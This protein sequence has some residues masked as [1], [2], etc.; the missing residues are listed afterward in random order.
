METISC[1]TVTRPGKLNQL[2]R[3][4]RCFSRQTWTERELV[5]VH[6][7]GEALQRD[8]EALSATFS[9][10]AIRVHEESPGQPLGTLRNASVARAR[11]GLVCQWDDDDLY[12]PQRLEVQAQRLREEDAE[13]CFFTDQMHL[14]TQTGEMYWDDW[15]REQPPMH[16]I[17]GTLLG[18]RES[19]APYPPLSRGEDTPLLRELVRRGCR[20]AEL[21]DAGCLYV[22]VYDGANAFDQEHHARISAWKRRPR[23]ALLANADA[24]LA[25]LQGHEWPVPHVFMPCE[26]G[27][28]DVVTPG[29]RA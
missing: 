3:A 25:C 19:M 1:L 23:E 9:D 7:G 4:M 18:V 27:R 14:F 12:H 6:D 11:G 29:M 10:C 13:F 21:R 22:Y 8:I 24:L 17:Q 28:L 20:V 5:V 16:L 26:G 2:E 15:T